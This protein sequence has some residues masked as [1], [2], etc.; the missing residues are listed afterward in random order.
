MQVLEAFDAAALLMIGLPQPP[1]AFMQPAH[2]FTQMVQRQG[3]A[4]G[5]RAIADMQVDFDAAAEL[6]RFPF[7]P[8][9]ALVEFLSGGPVLFENTFCREGTSSQKSS[10]NCMLTF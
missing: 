8:L 4:P 2:V 3:V 10:W 9:Q 6:L 1:P 7:L 5:I